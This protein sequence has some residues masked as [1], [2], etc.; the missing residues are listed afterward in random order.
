[1]VGRNVAIEDARL[2][3]SVL[4]DVLWHEYNCIGTGQD[5]EREGRADWKDDSMKAYELLC[6]SKE[7]EDLLLTLKDEVKP[8]M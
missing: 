3:I 4:Q 5:K 2:A 1:M 8:C 7:I 6:S